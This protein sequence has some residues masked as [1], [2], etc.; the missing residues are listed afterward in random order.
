MEP[1]VIAL[2]T[3]IVSV[4]STFGVFGY[5][6]KRWLDKYFLNKDE[7]IARARENEL[8]LESINREREE[9]KL[10]QEII[11]VIKPM[12]DKLEAIGSGTL[13]SLRNDILT[14]YY[15]CV[16]KGYR[17]D[18]DYTN[19]HDLYDSYIVLHGNSFIA[20]VMVRFDLLLTKEEWEAK[21]KNKK[22]KKQLNEN[23]SSNK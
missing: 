8:K 9:E 7:K 10:K 17:N 2:I 19:I 6:G 15:R 21:N 22:K 4:L 1:W 12:E 23:A 3:G 13:S 11:D 14:C 5:L 20:D 18:W 16:E